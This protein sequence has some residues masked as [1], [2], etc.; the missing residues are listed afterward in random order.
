PP[1]PTA[2]QSASDYLDQ[3]FPEEDLTSGLNGRD[4]LSKRDEASDL[5]GNST[6]E[7]GFSTTFWTVQYENIEDPFFYNF[8]LDLGNTPTSFHLDTP[9]GTYTFA[10]GHEADNVPLIDIM[11]DMHALDRKQ[12]RQYQPTVNHTFH[13]G[14]AA[15]DEIDQ[16]LNSGLICKNE[17]VPDNQQIDFIHDELRRK[18]LMDLSPEEAE[19]GVCNNVACPTPSPTQPNG[20]VATV[21]VPQD[22]GPSRQGNVLY[23]I[24]W[25]L[26]GAAIGAAISVTNDA[27]YSPHV[28]QAKGAQTVAEIGGALGIVGSIMARQNSLGVYNAPAERAQATLQRVGTVTRDTALEIPPVTRRTAMRGREAVN[29]NVIIAWIR[30]N[31][32]RFRTE[33]EAQQQC[34]EQGQC[35]IELQPTQSIVYQPIASPDPGMNNK[36]RRGMRKRQ[37][38]QQCVSAD[39]AFTLARQLG[40]LYST[41]P[42]VLNLASV[43]EAYQL[44]APQARNAGGFCPAS[45]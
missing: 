35:L 29:Q 14:L 9:V 26:A 27:M 30:G 11:H 43:S 23:T 20:P 39:E 22:I 32:R 3:I 37:A 15:L 38:N 41:E 1:P 28:V 12:W 19:E 21:R 34:D 4:L 25:S 13:N 8:T 17:T 7:C 33:Y 45:G 16:I 24:L 44:Y 42:G 40:S 5:V 10:D 18:L 2:G 36:M 6:L 31:L